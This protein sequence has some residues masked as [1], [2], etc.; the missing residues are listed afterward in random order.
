MPVY[1]NSLSFFLSLSLRLRLAPS[2]FLIEHIH[3]ND[4]HATNDL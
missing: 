4:E 3:T 2:L 1:D